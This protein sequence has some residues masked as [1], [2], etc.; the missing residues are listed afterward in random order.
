MTKFRIQPTL[1]VSSLLLLISLTFVMFVTYRNKMSISMFGIHGNH[2]VPAGSIMIVPDYICPSGWRY[3]FNF[4]WG[5]R[6]GTIAKPEWL[7]VDCNF[8]PDICS[9][10]QKD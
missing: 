1:I 2:S 7:S 3:M 8:M 9:V 5:L 6:S 10:C 4:Y